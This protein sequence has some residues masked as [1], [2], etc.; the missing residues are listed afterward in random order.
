MFPNLPQRLM[1]ALTVVVGGLIW[2]LAA[3]PLS[4]G[5]ALGGLSL[6]QARIG[7]L[8]ALGLWLVAA[9]PA[10]GLGLV[11]ASTGNVLGGVF[12]TAGA[13]GLLAIFGGPIDGWLW[14]SELPGAYAW[15]AV[16][17]AFMAGVW[18]GLLALLQWTSGP[19][20]AH[21][22]A[23]LGGHTPAHASPLTRPGGQGLIA[24]L[25]T[26]A[27]GGGLSELLLKT[28]DVG[29]VMWGL[30][31]GFLLAGLVGRVAVPRASPAMPLLAPFLTGIVAYGY[32]ALEYLTGSAVIAAWYG[33]DLPGLGLALPIHYASAGL[34][35]AAMGVGAGQL[36]ERAHRDEAAPT[37]ESAGSE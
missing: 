12:A 5:D 26:A 32:L 31:L 28:T 2:A 37:Q 35:G 14:R 25:A 20:R 13:L 34:A 10:V 15:L 9:L 22:G 18:A 3:G 16:E 30:V 29:Q 11:T 4:A 6:W 21:I 27:I 17:L 19:L 36:L 24:L 1:I 23:R 33:G 8:A 7:W